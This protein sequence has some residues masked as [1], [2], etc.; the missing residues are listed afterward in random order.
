MVEEAEDACREYDI[1]GQGA[2]NCRWWRRVVQSSC[3]EHC[4]NCTRVAQDVK[5]LA[6]TFG[7]IAINLNQVIIADFCEVTEVMFRNF[8]CPSACFAVDHPEWCN[9]NAAYQCMR[10]CGNYAPCRCREPK[11]T[12]YGEPN[13]CVGETIMEG[14][15]VP[16][17]PGITY[18]CDITPQSCYYHVASGA[19]CALY[20]HC[21]TD[22]CIVKDVTCGRTMQDPLNER[23]CSDLGYCDRHSGNCFFENRPKGWPCNDGLDYT[24]NDTCAFGVCSG[25]VNYCTR[26]QVVCQPLDECTTGGVCDNAT[27][28]CTYEKLEDG[29]ECDDKRVFTV[30]DRCINGLC[31][32]NP[33]DLCVEWAV[34]CKSPDACHNPGT[35][36]PR[37][38]ECSEAPPVSGRPCDDRDDTSTNDTCIDGVCVGDM[39]GGGNNAKF[40]TRGNGECRDRDLRS[41]AR[42]SGD[43]EDE[44][45]CQ[46]Y[47]KKDY[48][49]AAYYFAYPSCSIYGTIRTQPP[50][51]TN[52]EWA[53]EAASDPP[54]IIIERTAPLVAGQREGV[55]RTKGLEG[56]AEEGSEGARW[57]RDVVFHPISLTIVFMAMLALFFARPLYRCIRRLREPLP[58]DDNAMYVDD[59]D[60][61]K[62]M[63]LTTV[64]AFQLPAKAIQD[65]PETTLRFAALPDVAAHAEGKLQAYSP[66]GPATVVADVEPTDE[67]ASNELTKEVVTTDDHATLQAKVTPPGLVEEPDSG[68]TKDA[69]E[70]SAQ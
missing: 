12:A 28:R 40:L 10:D 70:D 39:P 15:P 14:E 69:S 43:V 42:Y 27:G 16:N 7:L 32:G 59:D 23:E 6:C 3:L 61:I 55:C 24:E 48:Q 19:A 9:T 51:G 8:R 41:M 56:D 21:E 60:D 35:C 58:E 11:G 36:N 30:E 65:Q 68:T 25:I 62:A 31:A 5:D 46:E 49:C 29:T 57:D 63:K 44:R 33:V 50:G 37:T 17:L 52:R 38:G 53:F 22:H 67:V 20:R 64:E 34:E 18:S 47:C 2:A 4:A 1:F 26:D 45:E 54:A 66:R 13:Y